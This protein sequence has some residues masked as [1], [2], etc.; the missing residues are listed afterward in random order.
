VTPRFFATASLVGLAAAS[1]MPTA[2]F[3]QSVAAEEAAAEAGGDAEIVVTAQRREERQV[4][5]PI[6]VANLSAAQLETANVQQLADI[7]KITPGVRFDYAG[8]FFQPTIRGIGTAVTTSGGGGNVGIYIDGF[9]SPNPLATNTQLMNVRNIQV[10][11]GPQ[12]TLFGRNTTGGAI[13]I[14][15]ADPSIDP[16]GEFKISY[17][18]YNEVRAQ[19]YATMG[20]SDTVAI[21][22]EGLYARGDGWQRDIS[23]GGRRVGD[24]EN[25]SVRLGLKADLSDN[26]SVLL[27]YQHSESDDPRPLLVS[28]YFNPNPTALDP[29]SEGQPFYAAPGQFT[30]NRDEIASGP[31]PEFMRTTTDVVQGTIKADLGFANLTSYTQY[32]KEVV[33]ASLELDFSAAINTLSPGPEVFQLGLPNDNYTFT[34]ELLLTSQPGQR[35]EW[36]AGLFYLENRD[37]YIT[38]IDNFVGTPVGR[39]RLGGSS[40]TTKSYA[41]FFD[42]TYEVVDNLFLTAGIR[43]AH[44]EVT[45]AYW[46]TRFLAPS[47]TDAN[48]VSQPA[49]GGQVF[50]PGISSDRVTP[51]A[52]IRYKP[53]DRSSI[54]GSYTRG[55][56]AAIIDVGG[57][58]Q[59]LPYIC[60]DVEPEVIDAFELGY[61]YSDRTLSL[62]LSAFYYDY[63]NLQVSLFEAGTAAI[64]NAAKSR[65]YGLDG[66]VRYRVSDAFELNVGAA[67]TH[68]RYVEFTNAPIYTPCTNVAPAAVC[69][70][71]AT[72]GGF[73]GI[74]FLVLGQDLR[75]VPMQRTP[76]FTGNIGARYTTDLGGGRLSLS[77]NLYY[78]SK[79]Y[80]GPSGTQFPQ[81]AYETLS[82]R[83]EWSDASDRFSIAAYGDNVTNSRYLTQVQYNN[84]S[85]GSNWSKPVTY[86][87]ELGVRF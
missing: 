64:V 71:P 61:K 5:V 85:I 68:A 36:T 84:F 28:S 43:Y 42:A 45:D 34:Q 86:G 60:N 21:D 19:A 30:Y 57:T 77:G 63:K 18:R 20:I 16:G 75:N 3:A 55:Y 13:L 39:I 48:N 73:G 76:E 74:S 49:P 81:K 9:Y 40:T 35:L 32:R 11:K 14:Q 8:G 50:V 69:Q 22:I 23:N 38:H 87:I 65:I 82:L 1:L 12:G 25:W 78:T 59:N 56:K 80:F 29:V 62:E 24:Y 54:Y 72:S 26:V 6:T 47:Y 52:V 4:D 53:N 31:V 33:D 79:F 67:W 44:D 41:A 15:S 51:R 17:G 66:Q 37:T 7:S 83:A 70:A 2:V 46:N 27:R 58:C 10:L